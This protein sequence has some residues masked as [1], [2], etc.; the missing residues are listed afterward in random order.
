M[1][2]VLLVFLLI[3]LITGL[4]YG[5]EFSIDSF[6][7]KMKAEDNPRKTLREAFP[8]PEIVEI[9]VSKEKPFSEITTYMVN[10]EIFPLMGNDWNADPTEVVIEGSKQE[11]FSY[12]VIA[13]EDP[14]IPQPYRIKITID[15][16]KDGEM[17]WDYV[18]VDNDY[19]HSLQYGYGPFYGGIQPEEPILLVLYIDPCKQ[20]LLELKKGIN[21]G[22]EL[23]SLFLGECYLEEGIKELENYRERMQ[24]S[25]KNAS[26]FLETNLSLFK[27]SE[28]FELL[29][30][31]DLYYEKN[32]E[33]INELKELDEIEF[34]KKEELRKHFFE[35]CIS[36]IDY[37]NS[38]NYFSESV[39][40]FEVF[41]ESKDSLALLSLDEVGRAKIKM[42]ELKYERLKEKIRYHSL[43]SEEEGD[44]LD[45]MKEEIIGDLSKSINYFK[46]KKELP[47]SSE[48]SEIFNELKELYRIKIE[49]LEGKS[50]EEE[51]KIKEQA[52]NEKIE[53]VNKRIKETMN[54]VPFN[55]GDE[56]YSKAILNVIKETPP[57]SLEGILK[58]I[59]KTKTTKTINLNEDPYLLNEKESTVLEESDFEENDFLE[60]YATDLNAGQFW[61]QGIGEKLAGIQLLSSR[62]KPI[63]YIKLNDFKRVVE[64]RVNKKKIIFDE[65]A[66]MIK[67][68]EEY[69]KEKGIDE[70]NPEEEKGEIDEEI[71]QELY[72]QLN[73]NELIE[74]VFK[75]LNEYYARNEEKVV[76]ILEEGMSEK[77]VNL[78]PRVAL[79]RTLAAKEIAGRI[80]KGKEEFKKMLLIRYPESSERRSLL[81]YV[82]THPSWGE[83]KKEV[84]VSDEEWKEEFVN[85]FS[86]DVPIEAEGSVYGNPYQDGYLALSMDFQGN[87]I[88]LPVKSQSKENFGYFF[89]LKG[90]EKEEFERLNQQS[91]LGV[92][93]GTPYA[94]PGFEFKKD[95]EYD[96]SPSSSTLGLA[97]NE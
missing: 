90:K 55:A 41:L 88:G 7:I 89:D 65:E 77:G 8:I 10:Q 87:K 38:M 82:E 46:G 68:D 92:F 50:A 6:F 64:L 79:L 70:I 13:S 33:I 49:A 5:E 59:E 16:S 15:L 84:E 24:E 94:E 22:T 4:V 40:S 1:K 58:R 12:E 72:N 52:Y 60:F 42:I 62:D 91:D 97:F 56:S 44:S 47:N 69:I 80:I 9:A 57:E 93:R 19:G 85:R 95:I 17:N 43:L 74:K 36:Q 81:E 3:V 34:E 96:Y 30:R 35:N 32:C 28:L 86:V 83:Q 18:L 39:K 37:V 2:K 48:W 26:D 63:L 54:S 66:K 61:L 51:I 23:D 31:N 76:K 25:K 20:R 21:D 71:K 14:S 29:S 67:I 78:S 53:A 27:E 73:K 11:Y 75:E 45:E